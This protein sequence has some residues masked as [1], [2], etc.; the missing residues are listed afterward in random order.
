MGVMIAIIFTILHVTT[1]HKIIE[2]S[3]ENENAPAARVI[4]NSINSFSRDFN[5]V[6]FH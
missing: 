6:K 5:G 4:A 1:A 3:I 2:R